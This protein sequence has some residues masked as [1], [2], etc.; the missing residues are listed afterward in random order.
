MTEYETWSRIVALIEESQE[1]G[2]ALSRALLLERA[3]DV[4]VGD[5]N[6]GVTVAL[7]KGVILGMML[8]G[9]IAILG[10]IA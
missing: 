10:M 1:G 2:M 5:Y 9:L 6:K 8:G 4:W 7:M 3:R